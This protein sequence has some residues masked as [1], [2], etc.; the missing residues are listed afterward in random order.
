MKVRLSVDAKIHWTLFKDVDVSALPQVGN[1][2][3]IDEM[4]LPIKNVLLFVGQVPDYHVMLESYGGGVE[5]LLASGWTLDKDT[6]YTPDSEG[7][8]RADPAV[9]RPSDY[10]G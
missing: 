6:P 3:V 1:D 7:V 8:T 10:F 4:C 2:L 9:C 5:E